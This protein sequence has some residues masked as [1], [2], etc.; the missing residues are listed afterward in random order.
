MGNDPP[1]KLITLRAHKRLPESTSFVE[2]HD[3]D[4]PPD[5]Q[6]IGCTHRAFGATR[7]AKFGRSRPKLAEFEPNWPNS[8]QTWSKCALQFG[9]V[10]SNVGRVRPKLG[11]ML[12]PNAGANFSRNQPRLA[13]RSQRAKVG[14]E[15]GRCWST[16]APKSGCRPPNLANAGVQ[17]SGVDLGGWHVCA[18]RRRPGRGSDT[19]GADGS[20][21]GPKGPRRRAAISERDRRHW[22]TTRAMREC[23][24]LR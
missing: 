13:K 4:N 20:D 9:R 18:V 10:R 8:V 11:P 3:S 15:C 12:A 16:W 6:K 2:I 1:L 22:T 7:I 5:S 17:P 14:P 19:G 24:R 21:R 23:L